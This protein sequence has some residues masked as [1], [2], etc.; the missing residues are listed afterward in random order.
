MS[1]FAASAPLQQA[2]PLT[3]IDTT[4]VAAVHD[5][6]TLVLKDS[7]ELRLAAIEVPSSSR[8]ALLNLVAGRALRLEKLGSDYDYYGRLVDHLFASDA[9]QS[10]PQALRM[11]GA[12]R[13]S[14][15]I[16]D[17]ACADT[18]LAAEQT[19][20]AGRRGPWGNPNFAPLPAENRTHFKGERGHF[21]LAEGKILSACESGG[22]LFI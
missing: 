11:Q 20:R 18:L 2:C 7:R 5:S 19:A 21:A 12:A 9:E 10:V 13:V 6:R 3:A 22:T 16:G 8:T 14:A 1:I 17:M 15:R 4:T